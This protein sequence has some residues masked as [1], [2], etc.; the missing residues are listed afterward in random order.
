MNTS[1]DLNPLLNPASIAVVGAS[2]KPGAGFL[3]IDNLRRLGF[4]GEVIPVNPGYREVMG[5]PCYPT[6]EDVPPDIEIDCVAI[7]LGAG[8]VMGVLEQAARRG[9]RGA[10][11][12]ASGFAETDAAGQALQARLK[13]FCDQNG[14][15][16]CGPNCVGYVNL[17]NGVATFS[18]PVSPT[19]R[20]GNIA[21]VV[22]SGSVALALAN[23]N[24]GIGFSTLVSSGNEAVLDAVDYIEHFL[25]DDRTRVIALFL[26]GI[27]RPE[28][29]QQACVRA[30]EAGKPIVLVKVGRSEL[31]RR[32]VVSHTGALAGTDAVHDAVFNQLGVVRVDDLDQLMETAA[33]FSALA[34]R[35][36]HGNRVGM[37][38]VSGGEIGLVGDLA[39]GLPIEFPPL[40]PAAAEA[41]K[42]KLPP[43]TPIANPLDAWGSGDL[44]NTYPACLDILAREAAVDLIAVSQ[45]SPP[46]MAD[47]QVQQYT[48]VAEA[49][50]RCAAGNKPVVV[51]SHVSGGLDAT[52]KRILDDGGV[53]FLQGTRESLLAI[54]HLTAYGHYQRHFQR[55]TKRDQ[56]RKPPPEADKLAGRCGVLGYQESKSI[57]QAYGI[58]FPREAL[59]SKAEEARAAARGIGYPVV[60]KVQS[61]G[62]PHKTEAG[63]VRLGIRNDAQLADAFGSLR[64]THWALEP[65]TAPAGVLV[66]EMISP[67]AVETILGINRDPV[68]GP[69]VVLGMGGVFVEL[70]GDSVLRLP[71]VDHGQAME[72]IAALK[73]R[74]LFDGFR[75]RPRADVEAL[76]E[77]IVRVG[78]IAA[79]LKAVLVSLDLNPLM[80]L[81]E[82]QGVVAA[83]V[84]MECGPRHGAGQLTGVET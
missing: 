6:L 27:R 72:M 65:G 21:A 1:K 61:A 46:G 7:V 38:T 48:A 50:V 36:P 19:L 57:L 33:L 37:V 41:L 64:K 58:G 60:M 12:F 73:G 11:A 3:V 66:Q 23:S 70:L 54:G 30:A 14:I 63:L 2:E 5:L 31:A 26:E 56:A 43:Y 10:W 15:C 16:F 4:S 81:P 35:L 40:S 67:D 32:T 44:E 42:T 39:Q 51:F 49:A 62:V 29:F 20:K 22:Q 71:P 79:G 80:V 13:A 84:L 78:D 83:D 8:R 69:V 75:G 68:F 17:Q 53:P 34:N 76:A 47:K 74:R 55:R 24:R 18:A 9:V 28:A 45:D 82:G 52:I 25:R 59:V 77:A